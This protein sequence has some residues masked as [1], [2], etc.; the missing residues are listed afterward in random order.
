[1]RIYAYIA[2]G[3]APDASAFGAV[4][5]GHPVHPSNRGLQSSVTSAIAR[6]LTVRIQKILKKQQK[7]D[8]K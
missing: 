3:S 2:G 1:M 8:E 6:I 4:L 7:R 5:S